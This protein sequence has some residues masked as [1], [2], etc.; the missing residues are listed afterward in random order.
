M[1]NPFA[2]AFNAVKFR[3]LDG[4]EGLIARESIVFLLL[5]AYFDDNSVIDKYTVVNSN[6]ASKTATYTI[7]R[8][9][10]NKG[11]IQSQR[12]KQHFSRSYISLTSKGLRLKRELASLLNS[13]LGGNGK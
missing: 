1:L 10:E 5:C 8:S 11:F 2:I 9:L 7:M 6:K 13:P 3:S 4:N 12:S